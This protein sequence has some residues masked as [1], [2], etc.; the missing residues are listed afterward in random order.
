MHRIDAGLHRLPGIRILPTWLQRSEELLRQNGVPQD[1]LP[2]LQEA[3]LWMNN[4]V[5]TDPT[6]LKLEDGDKFSNGSFELEVLWTPGHSPGHICL[7]E[8]EKKF[9]L[10]W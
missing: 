8:R 5:T 6:D 1:E 3:S 7:Y 4:Y 10:S 2:E 9:I